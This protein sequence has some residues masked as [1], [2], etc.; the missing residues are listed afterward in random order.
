MITTCG[1][2]VAEQGNPNGRRHS[3]ENSEEPFFH[4]FFLFF[5]TFIHLHSPSLTFIGMDRIGGV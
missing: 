2:I 3:P 4:Q 5:F 1:A